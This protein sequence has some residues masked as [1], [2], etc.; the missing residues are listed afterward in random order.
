MRIQIRFEA[1]V[2]SIK[3]KMD[4][5]SGVYDDLNEK[6]HDVDK[7]MWVV[8]FCHL[9]IPWNTWLVPRV[10]VFATSGGLMMICT[11]SKNNLLFYGMVPDS[12]PELPNSLGPRVL[13]LALHLWQQNLL[14][15][16]WCLSTLIFQLQDL[17][18]YS[19]G[20]TRQLPLKKVLC[21]TTTKISFDG[22]A[23]DFEP[24]LY[25]VGAIDH[26]YC[27]CYLVIILN[28]SLFK[29]I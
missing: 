18:R 23:L 28:C 15:V 22:T 6:M 27:Y 7:T 13:L 16:T 29:T 10:R 19:L 17:F 2:K 3:A 20:I 4:S 11:C 24:A 14:H 9:Q 5:I 1:E 8:H 26:C 25:L 21:K 12:L